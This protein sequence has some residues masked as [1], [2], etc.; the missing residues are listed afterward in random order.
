M[1][2]NSNKRLTP[3]FVSTI[4][5][6]I[7]NDEFDSD[8]GYQSLSAISGWLANNVGLLN[9][10]LYTSFSGSATTDGDTALQTTGRF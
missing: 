4:A 9:T 5:T 8:T 10:Q 2:W 3:Y 7:Y 6:G 1:A